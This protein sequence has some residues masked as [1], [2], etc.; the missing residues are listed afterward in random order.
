MWRPE[1]LFCGSSFLTNMEHLS[2]KKSI[3]GGIV[4]GI[5]LIISFFLFALRPV[6]GGA[7][8]SFAVS[9]GEGLRA[10]VVRL[11]SAGLIH[12]VAIFKMA[13]VFS[14]SAHTIKPGRYA[15]DA[16]MSNLDILNLL[17]AGP[18][19]IEVTI[20]EG[21]TVAEIDRVLAVN[22]IIAPGEFSVNARLFEGFLFPDTYRF[23]PGAP[24][25]EIRGRFL[26]NFQEKVQTVDPGLAMMAESIIACLKKSEPLT[27][28][29]YIDKKS[30]R[31]YNAMIV[32][33]LLEK[34]VL[35]QDE[36]SAVAGVIN[37]RLRIDMPLQIDATV[38]Y[39]R[40][41]GMFQDCLPLVKSDFQFDSPYN[42]YQYRG[43]PP[44]PIS[45]PGIRAILAAVSP[46]VNGYLFYLTDPS[47]SKTV[48]STTLEEHN[49][50]RA[51]YL[52]L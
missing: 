39:A 12:S 2:R 32:A 4:I 16:S 34:E 30:E 19:D 15:L 22:K 35:F 47:S 46:G 38:I 26:E 5:T 9:P 51:R 45:N 14:G 21:A 37:N 33:S 13:S 3:V 24:I 18:S 50:K 10:I 25:D 29:R 1:L 6:G 43:L 49:E 52:H 7:A 27:P 40:C 44:G 8:V 31:F 11:K 20:P 42:T 48:F 23:L 17:V 41:Q 28:C 36:L